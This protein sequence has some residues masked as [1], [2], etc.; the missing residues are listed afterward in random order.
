MEIRAW[1]LTDP[2]RQVCVRHGQTRALPRWVLVA[3][4]VQDQVWTNSCFDCLSVDVCRRSWVQ[5]W[6]KASLFSRGCL[7]RKNTRMASNSVNA[8]G[9]L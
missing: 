4:Y 6:L 9:K 1:L 7:N 8:E 5:D 2:S 3:V